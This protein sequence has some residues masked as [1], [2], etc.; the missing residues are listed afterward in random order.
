MK[1]SRIINNLRSELFSFSKSI[2]NKSIHYAIIRIATDFDA[3][4][5]RWKES[6]NIQP[7]SGSETISLFPAR[8]NEQDIKGM[9][10]LNVIVL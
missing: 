8:T 1:N 9:K 10:N 2:E 4:F 3:E 5:S 7:L 6:V